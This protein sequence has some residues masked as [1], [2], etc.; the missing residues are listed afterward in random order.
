MITHT[1]CIA[2]QSCKELGFMLTMAPMSVFIRWQRCFG[3]HVMFCPTR[4]HCFC[5][6]QGATT[7]IFQPPYRGF[8]CPVNIHTISNRIVTNA[9][10]VS[11]GIVAN[12]HCGV[13]YEMALRTLWQPFYHN[14][15]RG[16][17][18]HMLSVD[19]GDDDKHPHYCVLF[20]L[21]TRWLPW[22]HSHT[23]SPVLSSQIPFLY[24]W[25]KRASSS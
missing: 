2:L 8:E 20:S 1:G 11:K 16:I 9:Q 24:C 7:E 19:D 4:K 23:T 10:Y 15:T 18:V 14:N 6:G 13:C 12:C 22:R 5:T 3:S 25:W 17:T 21:S